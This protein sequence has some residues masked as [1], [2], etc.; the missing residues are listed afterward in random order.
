MTPTAVKDPLCFDQ[1]FAA[2]IENG[3]DYAEALERHVT[4]RSQVR[5]AACLQ[6]LQALSALTIDQ[7]QN[8]AT[9]A[10]QQQY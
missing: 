2:D 5:R 1:A 3:V 8:I 10:K 9:W 7:V 6:T 4:G